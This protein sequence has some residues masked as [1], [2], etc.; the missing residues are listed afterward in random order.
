MCVFSPLAAQE[1][2]NHDGVLSLGVIGGANFADMYFPNSQGEDDQRVTSRLGLAAGIVLDLHLSKN[3]SLRLEPMFVQKGGNIEEGNDPVN[4]PEG[5]LKTTA[6]ELPVMIRYSFGKTIR[7]YVTGGA[8]VGINLTSEMVFDFTGL[9]F[10]VDLKDVIESFD[11]GLTFGGGIQLDA[12]FGVLFI[13][14][15][16]SL[17]LINQR[18]TGIVLAKSGSI[19]FEMDGEKERDKYFSRDF[20]LL[21]GVSVPVGKRN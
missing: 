3:V 17:G 11:A 13:E 12:G 6:I 18:K 9:T 7:P 2:G 15:R 4:Q 14:S 21:A 1:N 5:Y 19:Q 8:S 10:E 20:L 16:Y